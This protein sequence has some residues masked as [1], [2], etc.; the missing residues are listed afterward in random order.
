MSENRI[1]APAVRLTPGRC[2]WCARFVKA[3]TAPTV[4][5][6]IVAD[7]YR[8][9]VG[10]ARNIYARTL[11]PDCATVARSIQRPG[12]IAEAWQRHNAMAA[13]SSGA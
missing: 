2:A 4:W 11:C 13:T 6:V 3:D 5:W 9:I 10:D 1:P 12:E 7:R 8:Q